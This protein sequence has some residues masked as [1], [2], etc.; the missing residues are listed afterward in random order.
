MARAQAGRLAALVEALRDGAALP[1]NGIDAVCDW[2][3]MRGLCRRDYHSPPPSP[4]PE[5]GDN[6]PPSGPRHNGGGDGCSPP[7]GGSAL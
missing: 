5:G 6:D 7:A 3:E 1:A 2:C 4:R